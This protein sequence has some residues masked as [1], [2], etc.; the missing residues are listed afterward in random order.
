MSAATRYQERPDW[1]DVDYLY[2]L[3]YGP[4]NAS[5]AAIAFKI[6][7]NL[8]QEKRAEI[9][10]LDRVLAHNLHCSFFPNSRTSLISFDCSPEGEFVNPYPSLDETSTDTIVWIENFVVRMVWNRNY[11]SSV[12]GRTD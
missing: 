9:T 1:L 4:A 10:L 3:N 8:G 6:I 2:R 11:S 12:L 5:D 7:D